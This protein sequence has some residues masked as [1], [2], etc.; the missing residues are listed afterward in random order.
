MSGYYFS[1]GITHTFADNTILSAKEYIILTV[2]AEVY[3]IDDDGFHENGAIVIEW[4]SGNLSN[5]GES[6]RI[7]DADGSVVDFV[8]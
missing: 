1:E 8:D 7:L 5:G 2:N 4:S 6:I 3:D